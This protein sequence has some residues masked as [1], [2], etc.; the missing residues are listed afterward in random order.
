MFDLYSKR[1]RQK[2]Q[3]N[4]F[5]YDSLPNPLKVQIIHIWSETFAKFPSVEIYGLG[6]VYHSINRAIT[7]E[8][9][10]FQLTRNPRTVEED[11]CNYFLNENEIAHCLDVI[12]IVFAHMAQ[13]FEGEIGYM[14]HSC[15][16]HA[17]QA[18]AEINARFKE[19]SVG[20]EFRDG[21]IIRIDSGFIHNETVIP[22]MTLLQD[23]YLAGA[24][25]EF[26]KAHEHFR[27]GRHAETINECL[28]A[29]ESTMKAICHKRRWQYNQNDTAKTLLAA[30]EKNGLFPPYMQS[31]L[32]GLRNV[33]ENVATV[34]N[35]LSGHG[36][37]VQQIQITEDT[38]AFVIHA[39]ASNILYLASLEKKCP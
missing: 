29:F 8:R 36:Q 12:E 24:N 28:K 10:V 35:K 3:P 23:R 11:V 13:L 22:A 4:I 25:Q 2:K 33:L 20:F 39:T 17:L 9:G 26:L 38:A 5:T 21:I 30:C 32:A 18:V 1:N 15:Q 37:G 31:S 6:R 16:G 7:K 19:H 34:R 14:N 27:N